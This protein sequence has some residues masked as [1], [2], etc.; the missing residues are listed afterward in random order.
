MKLSFST[1]GWS[2]LSWEEWL[3]AGVDMRFEGVE[4]YNLP[5]V[6]ALTEKSGPFHKYNVATTVRQMKEKKLSIPCF[7]TS[8]DLSAEDVGSVAL[9]QQL[10][11]LA[12]QAEVPYVSVVA[13]QDKEDLVRARLTELLPEAEA[14]ETVEAEE[15]QNPAEEAPAATLRKPRVF[16]LIVYVLLAIPIT[17]AGLALLLVPTLL[18]LALALLV[19]VAGSSAFVATFS[20][21]AVF[22]DLMVVLGTALVVSALGLLLLWLFVWFVGGAMV[23]LVQ[24]VIRLGSRCCYKEVAAS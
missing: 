12:K 22:A 23:G 2:H 7:D 8:C 6:A 10:I 4:V 18:V 21:F 1:R 13:L 16:L 9:I 24:Q 19:T 5:Y 11:Q 15:A 20:G 3:N 14:A 17:L